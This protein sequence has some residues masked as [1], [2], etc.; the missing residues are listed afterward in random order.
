M[1]FD[2]FTIKAQEIIQS[3]VM[4][5]QQKGQQTIEAT[6]QTKQINIREDN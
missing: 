4:I 3:A 2:K 5:A 6:E 1:T